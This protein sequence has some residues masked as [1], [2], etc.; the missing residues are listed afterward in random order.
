MIWPGLRRVSCIF[1][2]DVAFLTVHVQP[3]NVWVVSFLQ[4][5][6]PHS[7]PFLFLFA[8]TKF[9]HWGLGIGEIAQGD[10]LHRVHIHL[11]RAFFQDRLKLCGIE[12]AVTRLPCA[13]GGPASLCDGQ[14]SILGHTQEKDWTNKKGCM[15]AYILCCSQVSWN[16]LLSL[17]GA[18]T[19]AF[20]IWCARRWASVAPAKVI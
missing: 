10:A 9:T 11:R 14:V 12:I 16:G 17:T 7:A 1:N 2:M 20:A 19:T 4:A 15:D 3:Q 8:G 5:L 6:R 13:I 18:L